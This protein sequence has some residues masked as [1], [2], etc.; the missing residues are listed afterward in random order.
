MK[1]EKLFIALVI[2]ALAVLCLDIAYAV[3]ASIN[4]SL[5][6]QGKA[7]ANS[8]FWTFSLCVIII[9][10]LLALFAAAFIFLRKLNFPKKQKH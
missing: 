9:N 1:K 8:D 7:F 6:A 5:F 3:Y 2:S 4:Y 10:A